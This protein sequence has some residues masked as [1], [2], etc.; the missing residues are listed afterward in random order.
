MLSQEILKYNDD[1]SK[2]VEN[3]WTYETE[4]MCMRKI[5]NLICTRSALSQPELDASLKENLADFVE[6]I[7][8][9][10]ER[11]GN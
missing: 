3:Y 1:Q 9:S 5:N 10:A 4:L 7:Y 2:E 6:E 8:Y 11:A